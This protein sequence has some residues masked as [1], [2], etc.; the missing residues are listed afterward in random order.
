MNGRQLAGVTLA[1]VAVAAWAL[2]R[3]L[4]DEAGQGTGGTFAGV[5]I[6]NITEEI[7]MLTTPAPFPNAERNTAAFLMMIRAAEGTDDANGYR[8]LFGHR[9][10]R[11]RLFDGWTDHPRI[12]T[13]FTD[14]QGRRLWTSAAGAYQFMA[15]SPIP[16][17]GSTR[18]DTWDR[19]RDRYRLPDFSPESQDRAAL[20]LIDEAG[21]LADVRA[22]RVTAA[23]DKCRRIWA[24]LPG[25]GYAQP[26]RAADWLL[27][28]YQ[29]HGGTFA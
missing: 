28:R 15:R 9:P 16:G 13:Q 26:E 27:S 5:N 2:R 3:A 11:P 23:I 18:V 22:G 1:G 17:G 10:S 19:V 25:A 4:P 14:G 8:A 12:A 7:E 29:A 21:A 24:S 6:D 20:A